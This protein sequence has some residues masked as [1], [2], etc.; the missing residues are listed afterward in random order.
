MSKPARAPT[1][2]GRRQSSHRKL[3]CA[4]CNKVA[5]TNLSSAE[6]AAIIVTDQ[7]GKGQFIAY[8]NPDCR[9]YHI[10][11]KRRA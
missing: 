2:E 3:L 4:V 7:A 6:R 9:W 8:F 11:H 1:S 5:Y 10:G